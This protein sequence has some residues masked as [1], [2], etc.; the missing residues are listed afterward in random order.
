M[1][2]SGGNFYFRQEYIL[3][4]TCKKKLPQ[5]RPGQSY[6]GDITPVDGV[7]REEKLRLEREAIGRSLCGHPDAAWFLSLWEDFEAGASAEARFVRELDRLEMGLEAALYA[8]E[9]YPG[10]EEF[11]ESSRKVVRDGR[12]K[13]ILEEAIDASASA[14]SAT[15]ARAVAAAAAEAR[16]KNAG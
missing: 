12:L 3:Q 2:L 4:C 16:G 9:G 13:A 1:Q 10:M 11:F 6:A 14:A 5:V 15:A 7:S 8:S